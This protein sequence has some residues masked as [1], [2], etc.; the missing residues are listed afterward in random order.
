METG[1]HLLSNM[2]YTKENDFYKEYNVKINKRIYKTAVVYKMENLEKLLPIK[3]E[4]TF[5]E[6]MNCNHDALVV[7]DKF[8]ANY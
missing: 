2:I 8:R 4:F 7:V 5:I 1:H 3:D 6:V